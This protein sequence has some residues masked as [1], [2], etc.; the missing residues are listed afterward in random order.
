MV[1]PQDLKRCGPCSFGQ[2]VDS[3]HPPG[4]CTN[5]RLATMPNREQLFDNARL[6]R[7]DPR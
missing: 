7:H 2:D 4:F 6:P 1:V 5:L 3:V